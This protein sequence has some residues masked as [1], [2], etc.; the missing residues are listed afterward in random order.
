[1]VHSLVHAKLEHATHY[2]DTASSKHNAADIS[3]A[4]F[5]HVETHRL[6]A[7]WTVAGKL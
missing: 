2:S 5:H 1:M 7:G 3:S 6:V 4:S